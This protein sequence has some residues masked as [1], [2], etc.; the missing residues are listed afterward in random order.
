MNTFQ[1]LGYIVVYSGKEEEAQLIFDLKKELGFDEEYFERKMN[2][3]F[4][5]NTK[6]DTAISEKTI[7][8]FYSQK[9]VL[10]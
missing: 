8:D 7:F 3:F 9:K 5:Y 4:G 6:V 10:L 2:F 1:N